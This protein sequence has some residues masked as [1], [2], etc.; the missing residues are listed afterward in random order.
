MINNSV[1]LTHHNKNRT[2]M[3]EGPEITIRP[4]ATRGLTSGDAQ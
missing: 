2:I 3:V 4:V 1:D